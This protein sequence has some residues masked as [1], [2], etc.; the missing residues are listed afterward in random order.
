MNK[1]GNL[2]DGVYIVYWLFIIAFLFV[3]AVIIVTAIYDGVT[4]TPGMSSEAVSKVTTINN[5]VGWTLDFVF[6]MLLLSFPM[7]SMILG[8]FNN[9]SPFLFWGVIGITMLVVILAGAFSDAWISFSTSSTTTAAVSRLPMTKVV[10]DNFAIYALL[11]IILI[12][13]GVFFKTK[14]SGGFAR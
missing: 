6:L 4:G 13:G 14:G 7:A 10:L 5:Q 2:F 1:Q 11:C 9:V 3:I 12:A 8:F